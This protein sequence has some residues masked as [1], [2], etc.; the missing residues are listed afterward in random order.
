MF[1]LKVPLSGLFCTC[2]NLCKP[3]DNHHFHKRIVVCD[4]EKGLKLR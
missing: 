4:E 2:L 1:N 3:A